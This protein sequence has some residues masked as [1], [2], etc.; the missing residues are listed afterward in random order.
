LLVRELVYGLEGAEKAEFQSQILLNG[1]LDV[2]SPD[3][4]P[5]R[6]VKLDRGLLSDITVPSRA[7]SGLLPSKLSVNKM[8]KSGGFYK[9]VGEGKDCL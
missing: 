6:F 3:Q 7:A 5:D 1:G 4:I 9:V 2:F 8:I